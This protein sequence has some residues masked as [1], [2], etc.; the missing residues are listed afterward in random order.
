M[1]K[2]LLFVYGTLLKGLENSHLLNTSRFRFPAVTRDRFYMISNENNGV[3]SDG[4]NSYEP[5]TKLDPQERY[6]YPYLLKKPVTDA[7]EAAQIIGEVYEVDS[8]VLAQLD[9]LEEHP[10]VYRR[11]ELAILPTGDIDEEVTH[12]IE[13]YV[14]ENE[15]VFQ[16]LKASMSSGRYKIVTGG[17]WMAKRKNE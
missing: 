12:P 10:A 14:L 9:I 13:G 16:D 11:Q 7:Q 6:K 8:E 15:E 3:E 5:S 17:S 4:S 2:H 1:G